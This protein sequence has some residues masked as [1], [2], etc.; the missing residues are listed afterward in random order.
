MLKR[1]QFGEDFKWG[2][3]ISAFQN[4]GAAHADNKGPSIWDTFTADREKIKNGDQIG[5][6]ASFYKNYKEDIALTKELGFDTF[7]F[8]I[9]WP[10][11]LPN[12]V[13]EINHKGIEFYNN[14]INTCL[15]EGL[16]PFVTL[17]HWDLPQALENK[18]GWTNRDILEW[19]SN[20]VE[21][22]VCYFGDR[23]TNWVVMN[24]PM[25]FIGL[26]Y[27][28]GYHAPE[29]K[30][31]NTFLRAAHHAILCMAEGGRILRRH[32]P[33]AHIGVALSCSYVKPIH[34]TSKHI[35]A[36][37]RTEAMLNRFFLEPLLGLGYPTDVMPAL[38]MIH[39]HFKPGDRQRMVFDFNFIGLQYY[40][41]VVA[42]YSLFPPVL[43]AEEVHPTK[44]KANLNSMNLDTYP[45]GL[46]KLLKFYGS[47][48]QIKSILLSESGVCYPDFF[49]ANRVHDARRANYHQHMLKQVKKA[50][51]QGIP[52]QGYFVW[53]LVDNFEWREGFEP[54]FGLVYTDFKT[55]ERTIKYSGKWF[56]QF[57]SLPSQNSA[58]NKHIY[59]SA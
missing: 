49:V 57:L 52:V 21:T 37:R 9:S 59:D 11:L 45:R 33:E 29:R 24:E 53:T 27:F 44:R 5:E 56:Q 26:G 42:K 6:A 23:V 1:K 2:V 32:Q 10:R 40:F 18:G 14:V 39:A 15:A 54:R 41:R 13:G 16:T 4:E 20:Y 58:D 51:R 47:Y 36:A 30:G 3:T 25:T 12:G 50:R 55:Q 46:G 28:M 48:P 38:K 8:S 19:F 43:F 34:K 31:V 22:C 17:Y 35:R 7:R